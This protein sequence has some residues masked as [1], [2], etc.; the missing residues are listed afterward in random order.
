VSSSKKY[1][2]L[3]DPSIGPPA[4][5][6]PWIPVGL[7]N[8]LMDTSTDVF[9]VDNVSGFTYADIE[10]AIQAQS[11]STNMTGFK[12]SLKAIQPSQSVQIDQLF[13]SYGY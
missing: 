5:P 1:L 12:A 8:D 2:D 4:E 7:I 3:F 13:A 11:S 6:F 10:S 9:V